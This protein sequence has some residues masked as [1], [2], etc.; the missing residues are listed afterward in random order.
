MVT[1]WLISINVKMFVMMIALNQLVQVVA[2]FSPFQEEE[3]FGVLV[4]MTTLNQFSHATS[5][6]S[7]S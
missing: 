5:F 4:M 2:L 1:F 6:L 3:V 7:S